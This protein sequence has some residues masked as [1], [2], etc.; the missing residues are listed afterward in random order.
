VPSVGEPRDGAPENLSR[1]CAGPSGPPPGR[2]PVGEDVERP[3]RPRWR[4]PEAPCRR[5][6]PSRPERPRL[7]PRGKD[8]Q[9]LRRGGVVHTGTPR[10]KSPLR[11]RREDRLSEKD[12]LVT[13]SISVPF[14]CD[15][16]PDSAPKAPLPRPGRAPNPTEPPRPC[17]ERSRSVRPA[18]PRRRRSLRPCRPRSQKP[19][20]TLPFTV[21]YARRR[22]R[23]AP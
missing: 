5:P 14:L 22:A 10:E 20:T 8:L 23:G 11:G 16:R 12:P 3:V 19:G 7:N 17:P 4:S 13:P 21:R 9:Q 15:R 18:R 1:R 6:G 2:S